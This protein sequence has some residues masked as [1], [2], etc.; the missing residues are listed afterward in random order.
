MILGGGALLVA[1]SRLGWTPTFAIMAALLALASLLRRLGVQEREQQLVVSGA[2][3][4]V[5]L[6]LMMER[7]AALR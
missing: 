6:V 5:A 3:M 2:A 7:A 1:F 4:G